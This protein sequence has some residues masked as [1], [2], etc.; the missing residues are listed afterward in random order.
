M[1]A[2]RLVKESNEARFRNYPHAGIVATSTTTTKGD[3]CF[4]N[5]PHAGIVATVGA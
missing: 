2:T 1:V 5:Y 3:K 4:R